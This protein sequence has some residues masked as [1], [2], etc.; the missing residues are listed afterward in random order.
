MRIS[1]VENMGEIAQNLLSKCAAREDKLHDLDLATFAVFE[2][3]EMLTKLKSDYYV[4]W[5]GMARSIWTAIN[6]LPEK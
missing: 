2:L 5:L 3:S 6:F 1:D 4:A